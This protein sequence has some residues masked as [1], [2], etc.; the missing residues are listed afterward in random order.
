MITVFAFINLIWSDL[1]DK[2]TIF[3]FW[4]FTWNFCLIAWNFR[5]HELLNNEINHKQSSELLLMTRHFNHHHHHHHWYRWKISQLSI[6]NRHFYMLNE[7]EMHRS[8]SSPSVHPFVH[9]SN[10]SYLFSPIDIYLII[11]RRKK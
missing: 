5:K 10:T 1:E 3:F 11:E 9:S 4:V 8:A 2:L 7:R 6:S